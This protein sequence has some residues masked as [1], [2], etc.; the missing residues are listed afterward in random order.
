MTKERAAEA[1]VVAATPTFV[2]DRRRNES[3]AP[4]QRRESPLER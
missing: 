4:F 2:Q 3:S 1:L